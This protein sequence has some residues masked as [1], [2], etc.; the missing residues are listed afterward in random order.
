MAGTRHLALLRAVNVGG[1]K[2]P[3]AQ[4]REI[5]SGLGWN[6]VA[7]YIQSG[8]LLF[9]AFGGT[10]A[11]EAELESA[12]EKAFGFEVPV[13]MR[14]AGQWAGYLDGNPFPDAARND[15]RLLM[16]GLAKKPLADRCLDQLR[17]VAGDVERVDRKGEALWIH[18]R[19]GSARSRITPRVLDRAAGSTVTTRNW[20]T[21]VRLGEMLMDD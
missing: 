3:M 11:L 4:L 20:R 8:N 19:E 10:G 9:S 15:P 5:A 14:T 21:A 17:E 7:T 1:R 6:D 2:V 13:L 18:F 16:I 12:L